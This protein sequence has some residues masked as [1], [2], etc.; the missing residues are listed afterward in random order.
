MKY[1]IQLFNTGAVDVPSPEVYWMCK[2]GEWTRL[3]FLMAVIQGGGKIV[4]LNTGFPADI[5]PLAKAWKDFLGDRA[6]LER[7][8]EWTADIA[9]PAA[10]IDP[11]SVD[12]VLLSPIQLYATGN[13][14]LFPNA[15]FCVSR[16]GW[17]EDIIAPT[18]HHHI[19]RQGCISD[20]DLFWLLDSQADRLLLMDDV[21]ELLPGLTCRWLG[22][23]HR[24]SF[25]TEV[26]T[27]RGRVILS[28]C[29]FHYANLEENIPLGIAESIIEADA[30]YRHIRETAK[31]FIPLYDPLVW[32]RHPDG[33]IS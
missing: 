22:V 27:G 12:Y 16:K 1:T 19:P 20:E 18:Y 31:I 26:E 15:K 25:T 32:E 11:A 5:Q 23:H 6:V 30:A 14:R 2:F 17:I 33:R 29:A 7:L 4:V 3:Q 24:S 21:H 13:L 28:D 10:G 8:P 9:L